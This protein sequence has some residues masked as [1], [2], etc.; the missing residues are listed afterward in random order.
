MSTLEESLMWEI[1]PWQR[2]REEAGNEAFPQSLSEGEG[3]AKR[4]KDE[5][6]KKGT[7]GK[8]YSDFE[9]ILIDSDHP[10]RIHCLNKMCHTDVV[11]G[12]TE[13]SSNKELLSVQVSPQHGHSHPGLYW[14]SSL[15]HHKARRFIWREDWKTW[16]PASVDKLWACTPSSLLWIYTVCNIT[17]AWPESTTGNGP[18]R[19]YYGYNWWHL[20]D[21][22]LLCSESKAS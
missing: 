4:A 22:S 6:K 3:E 20:M 19:R 2:R 11:T 15:F 12:R 21:S 18:N 13:G 7:E 8:K 10:G 9:V 17:R 16:T 5:N 14:L 1:A